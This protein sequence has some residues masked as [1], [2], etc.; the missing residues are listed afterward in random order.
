M[1]F[2]P[3]CG[4][5]VAD[6][7]AACTACGTA[8]PSAKKAA[9]ARFNGT[10]MMAAPVGV[11][12]AEPANANSAA[13]ANAVA[14]QMPA[15]ARGAVEAKLA[16]GAG[17][18]S[19]TAHAGRMP[20]A[21][22]TMIGAGIAPH[23]G[24]ATAPAATPSVRAVIDV[25]ISPVPHRPGSPGHAAAQ[26]QP[27]RAA[28]AQ[29]PADAEHGHAHHYLP[30]DPMAPQ[31]TA[32]DRHAHGQHSQRLHIDHESGAPSIP[33]EERIWLYWAVCGVVVL[34]VLVLAIGLF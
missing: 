9:G 20:T 6:D 30:G 22:A 17:V 28:A 27:P 8:L 4:K 7:T 12:V 26:A 19:S 21:K 5:S 29:P 31:P 32:A 23:V 11:K 34:S 2:C 10:V 24:A 15:S 13:S 1:A 16:V 3:E 14:V 25:P 18:V 33:K